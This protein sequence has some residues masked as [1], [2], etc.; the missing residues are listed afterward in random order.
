MNTSPAAHLFRAYDIRGIADSEIDPSLAHCV[1]R[2]IAAEAQAVSVK[3]MAVGADCRL[4][5]PAISTALIE[6]LLAGGIDAIDLGSVPSPLAYFAAHTMAQTRS[7][8]VVTASHNPPQY[9]GFKVVLDTHPLSG[10]RIHRLYERIKNSDYGPPVA[11]G[12]LSSVAITDDYC[13]EVTKRVQLQKPLKVVIDAGNSVCGL[14]APRLFNALGCEVTEL[15]C[16]PDGHFPNHHP[17]P[18]KPENMLVLA[19]TVRAEHADLGLA[20]DGDGD[21]LGVI[22]DRGEMV[23]P[24][25]LLMLFVG[26]ILARRPQQTILFDVKCSNILRQFIESHGG[27]AVMSPSGHSVIKNNMVREKACLAG[28]MSGHIFFADRWYGFDD[29]FYAGAR[30]LELLA[31]TDEPLSSLLACFPEGYITPELEIAVPENEKFELMSRIRKLCRPADSRPDYTDG[32][33]M[34]FA[35]GWGLVRASNT[36][37]MLTARFEGDTAD[38]LLRI[39]R[40]TQAQLLAIDSRLQLPADES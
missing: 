38:A 10:E 5:S 12:S 21:R 2:A 37:P 11:A 17:D 20:F 7:A 27:R 19:D 24:D 13:S 23:S 29:A 18:A 1:G 16:E 22:T 34:E 36:S 25:R 39:R 14:I 33:R 6:G 3:T 9:T 40:D 28:E 32:L 30:L 8:V 15:F 35:D 26:E 4:S 31:A